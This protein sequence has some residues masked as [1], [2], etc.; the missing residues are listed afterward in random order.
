[1]GQADSNCLSMG[2]DYGII[3]VDIDMAQPQPATKPHTA[4]FSLPLNDKE[5]KNWKC[6]NEKI[7]GLRLRQLKR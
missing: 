7:H 4:T 1:M 3:S 6:K 5:G 2:T